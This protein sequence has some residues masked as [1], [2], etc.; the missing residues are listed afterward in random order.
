[1]APLKQSAL[2]WRKQLHSLSGGKGG[3]NPLKLKTPISHTGGA[4]I[5]TKDGKAHHISIKA[6][7][8][9]P[10]PS[11]TS[12]KLIIWRIGTST[13]GDV[14]CLMERDDKTG[15]YVHTNAIPLFWEPDDQPENQTK[16]QYS[17]H[18]KLE[19]V[20]E[21]RECIMGKVRC[22]RITLVFDRYDENYHRIIAIASE[23]SAD[24]IATHDFGEARVNNDSLMHSLSSMETPRRGRKGHSSVESPANGQQRSNSIAVASSATL[25]AAPASKPNKSPSSNKRKHDNDAFESATSSS[26]EN[27]K[28]ARRETESDSNEQRRKS[29]GDTREKQSPRRIVSRMSNHQ[30]NGG[31]TYVKVEEPVVPDAAPSSTPSS[32]AN[33]NARG[34]AAAP[35]DKPL[36]NYS[37]HEIY[38]LIKNKGRVFEKLANELK[39]ADFNGKRLA[40]QIQKGDDHFDG[41]LDTI[42]ETKLNRLQRLSVLEEFKDIMERSL[43]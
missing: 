24:A 7:Q 35:N 1:M 9:I 10:L 3:I 41:F 12:K 43:S 37:K 11:D 33:L 26:E 28:K 20:E 15:K 34:V 21:K 14:K 19:N 23:L 18:W 25:P 31:A 8:N 13:T 40:R 16:V 6:K 17:G 38:N 39:D 29:F 4:A 36:D 5:A 27:A 32:S 30:T 42:C 22:A 2:I